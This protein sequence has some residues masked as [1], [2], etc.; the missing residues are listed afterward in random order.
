[1]PLVYGE[2]L[3][4]GAWDARLYAVR[5]DTGKLEWKS[6]CPSWHANLKSRYYAAADTSPAVIND[7]VLATDRGYNLGRYSLR[8]EFLGQLRPKVSAVTVADGAFYTRGLDNQ[9]VKY[10]PDG[11]QLWSLK[12]PLGR[13]PTAPLVIGKNVAV[14][15]DTGHLCVAD[16]ATGSEVFSLSISPSLFVLSGLGSDNAS[17]LFAADM[18]GRL[19]SVQLA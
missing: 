3:L 17:R 13:A 10:S 9:L 5:H 4:A 7:Q 16:A 18:D 1:M 14:V 19:T 8:G 2:L 11:A 12:T 6:W 15:S